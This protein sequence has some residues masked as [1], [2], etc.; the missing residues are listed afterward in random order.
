MNYIDFLD[1]TKRNIKNLNEDKY[2]PLIEHERIIYKQEKNDEAL[3][4]IW[5][6]L[7]IIES[8]ENYHNAFILLKEK[9]YKKGWDKFAKIEIGILD[10]IYNIPN[11]KDYLIVPFLDQYVRKY[12]NIY[13]YTHFTSM[14][15]IIK[16]SS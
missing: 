6:C 16:K 15:N 10:I 3:L 8:I 11:Y 9:K 13:P 5:L 12:Q 2:K 1:L 7:E 4:N 14:V